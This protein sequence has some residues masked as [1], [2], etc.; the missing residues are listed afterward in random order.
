MENNRTYTILNISDLAK[1]DFTQVGE[2]SENTIRKSIDETQ[3]VIK[4]NTTPSF[5]SDG[6]ITPIQVLNHTE[7]LELM[8]TDAWSTNE[9]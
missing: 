4:Y 7:V 9:E 6:T 8:A 1:V 5:I 2:T 3:F